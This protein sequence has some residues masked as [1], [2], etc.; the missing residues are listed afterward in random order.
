METEDIAVVG[1]KKSGK[2]R[3]HNRKQTPQVIKIIKLLA[4]GIW[5]YTEGGER[6]S[7]Q[8]GKISPNH[9]TQPLL[10]FPFSPPLLQSLESLKPAV[11][12]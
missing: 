3:K 10:V 7:V 8:K 6:E 5:R 12:H 9:S 11:I 2:T 1:I 4:C